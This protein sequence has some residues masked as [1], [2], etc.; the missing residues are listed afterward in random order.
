MTRRPGTIPWASWVLRNSHL[1]IRR[2]R[3]WCRL[4]CRPPRP[5]RHRQRRRLP[6]GR[7]RGSADRVY[8]DDRPPEPGRLPAVAGGWVLPPLL[9]VALRP[10]LSLRVAVCGPLASPSTL[11]EW[12]RGGRCHPLL[13]E[14][15][16]V[17][18]AADGGACDAVRA[19]YGNIAQVNLW[20][21]RRK[22]I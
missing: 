12:R 3:G 6:P 8:G 7:G 9:R 19:C 1:L 2:A 21:G 14:S 15:S 10:L 17:E 16:V 22:R 13:G 4:W 11:G 20:R 18:L 5:P